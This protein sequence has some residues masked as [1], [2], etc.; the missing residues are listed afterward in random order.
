M[1][2]LTLT[3]DFDHDTENPCEY[4]GW[5]FISFNHRHAS[6]Q[7]PC[8]YLKPGKDGPVGVS[9]ELRNKLKNGFAFILSCY[10]HSGIQWGLQGEV[11][12]CQW[13]TAQVAGLLI[14][15]DDK[16]NLPR[17]FKKRQA[18]ARNFLKTYTDWVNG[19][20]FCFSLEDEN[21]NDIGCCGG[22]IGAEALIE[23]VREAL[24]DVDDY[25]IAVK[26]EASYLADD[27]T[28]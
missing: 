22:Y 27:C 9:A 24:R 3:I 1:K 14:W 11:W 26:G 12:Q 5:E 15:N 10:E 18:D 6:F 7:H 20:C 16:T 13:D 21:G 19:A 8:Q 2:N 17:G 23:A 28:L 4:D 25:S